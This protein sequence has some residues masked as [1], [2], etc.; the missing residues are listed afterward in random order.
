M[1]APL[2]AL[3]AASLL[4]VTRRLKLERVFR[5]VDGGL[6]VFFA[7]LFVV[8]AAVGASGAGVR[9]FALLRPWADAGVAGLT[10]LSAA[11]SNLVSN[12]PAVLLLRPVVSGLADPPRAWLT[13]AMATTL[14]G[15]LTLLG[16]VANL[17]VAE[18]AR[19]HGVELSFGEYLKAGVPITLLT[20]AW[21]V[22]WLSVGP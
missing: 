22:L 4:L 20:L 7:G 12:V 21:G 2:A 18:T 16:S 6:L 11:L 17:I 3:G 5:E 9:L 19:R 8:T 13:L 10:A 14:A 1:P 15:N